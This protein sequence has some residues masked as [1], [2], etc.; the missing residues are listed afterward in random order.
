MAGR[1]WILHA[2]AHEAPSISRVGFAKR[3]AQFAAM[4][5]LL[6]LDRLAGAC[7]LRRVATD[8]AG[9]DYLAPGALVCFEPMAA[10]GQ[11]RDVAG[12][13]SP[14]MDRR[15]RVHVAAFDR[16]YDGLD[17]ILVDR[18]ALRVDL[19][20]ATVTYS[21]APHDPRSAGACAI[22]DSRRSSA[23]ISYSAWLVERASAR[24][25]SNLRWHWQVGNL[26]F[27]HPA[28]RRCLYSTEGSPLAVNVV[29]ELREWFFYTDRIPT[30]TE[31][32]A[33]VARTSLEAYRRRAA[34]ERRSRFLP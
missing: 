25:A 2:P 8:G 24:Q 17:G 5:V 6:D 32:N 14:H 34:Q 21:G 26:D 12:L 20:E 29:T 33:R 27:F 18:Q 30:F 28:P 10:G 9:Q 13:P 23:C 11:D 19:I 31:K 3:R 15:Q 16:R 22:S 4:Q 7:D 1:P